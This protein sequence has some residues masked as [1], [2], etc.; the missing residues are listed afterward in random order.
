MTYAPSARCRRAPFRAGGLPGEVVL[1]IQ[2]RQGHRPEPRQ[3]VLRSLC[4]KSA[5]R[6]HADERRLVCVVRRRE[7]EYEE[8]PLY[9]AT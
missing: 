1:D 3:G 8:L 7:E 5:T 9:T 2:Q 6:R 4:L